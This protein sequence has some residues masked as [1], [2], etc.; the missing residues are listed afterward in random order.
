MDQLI[1]MLN[2]VRLQLAGM[3]T[4]KQESGRLLDQAFE[5]VQEAQR[6]LEIVKTLEK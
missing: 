3:E 2:E 5:N 1:S 4:T 6:L